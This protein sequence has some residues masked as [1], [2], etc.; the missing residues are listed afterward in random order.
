MHPLQGHDE[1]GEFVCESI[2]CERIDLDLRGA[3]SQILLSELSTY[4][5]CV[6]DDVIDLQIRAVFKK[7]TQVI[8]HIEVVG[9]ARLRHDVADIYLDCLRVAHGIDYSIH[10]KVWDY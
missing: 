2:L 7:N 9:L 4:R 5:G 8:F 1:S 3:I 6:H 10:K